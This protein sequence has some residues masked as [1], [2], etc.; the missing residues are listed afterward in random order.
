MSC[1]SALLGFEPNEMSL[2]CGSQQRCW[3]IPYYW[4]GLAEE[5]RKLR[6]AEQEREAQRRQ[7][8]EHERPRQ[9]EGPSLG[10]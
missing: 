8:T 9:R 3:V 1:V 7:A 5:G 6:Q 4:Q 10:M 2:L